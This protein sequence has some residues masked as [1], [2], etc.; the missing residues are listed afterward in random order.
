MR[1]KPIPR[2]A[3][4]E[5]TAAFLR[6]SYAAFM[7]NT[8]STRAKVLSQLLDPRRDLD[9]ECGYV[10]EPTAAEFDEMYRKEGIARR[11]VNI[12][13]SE[14]WQVNPE[15]WVSEEPDDTEFEA[16]WKKLVLDY[17]LWSVM[18]RA[19]KIS[20][21]GR[22]GI[23]LLGIDDGKPLE[24]PVD[25]S[26]KRKH[27]LIYTRTFDESVITI[28]E[29][30]GNPNNPRFGKPKL[31]SVKFENSVDGSTNLTE[32]NIHWTRC[33]HLAD[34][35]R[36]SEVFGESRM[37]PVFNRLQDIRKIA[38]G[39]AEMFWQGA[40]P[41]LSFQVDPRFLEF[42]AVEIDKETLKR[43]MEEY[44]NGLQR[45]M[46]T[47]G[48]DV[49]SLAPQVY[50]PSHHIEI[51]LKLIA[52]A[53][54]VPYRVFMGTEEAKLASGQDSKTWAKR[55]AERQNKYLT[56]YV[57]REIIDRLVMFGVLP[58]PEGALH[59]DWPDMLTPSDQ[60]K[61]EV[62]KAKTSAMRDYVQGDVEMIYPLKHFLMDILGVSAEKANIIIEA[63]KVNDEFT[64]DAG[65]A[66]GRPAKTVKLVKSE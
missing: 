29:V 42:G 34:G 38:G 66:A 23:I 16:A 37:R 22:F 6:T 13:P 55:V 36:M 46:S 64:A 63:V 11:V 26:G 31:Y 1:E 5:E 10:R 4:N 52:L 24:Q 19:D 21:I 33:I 12:W 9:N 44:A 62:A 50:D 53:L 15:V 40:F 47:V 28:K 35:K 56:P 54:D 3:T 59:I 14:C 30:E 39:S 58:P 57:V 25:I 61:A 41:G 18:E 49:K 20:G 2:I 8:M 45:W 60:E 7:A 17:D 48:V 32:T 51:N 27:K 65:E 43:E